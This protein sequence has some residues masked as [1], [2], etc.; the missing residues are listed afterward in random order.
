[1]VQVTKLDARDQT[2]PQIQRAPKIGMNFA[3]NSL[4]YELM[5]EK[6]GATDYEQ[7]QLLQQ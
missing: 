6:M 4:M 5:Y 3:C 1:M 7:Q 2:S